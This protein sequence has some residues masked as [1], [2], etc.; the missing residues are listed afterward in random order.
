MGTMRQRP[1]RRKAADRGFT[2]V[3]LLIV[4][5]VVGI[6]AG[7]VVFGVFRFRDDANT[8]TDLANLKLLNNASA[9]YQASAPAGQS[10][11]DLP[12]DTARMNRLFDAKLLTNPPDGIK[13]ITPKVAG[14]SFTWNAASGLW[15]YLNGNT[16]DY[17]FA[18]DQLSNYPQTGSWT[19]TSQGFVST[20]GLLFVPNPRIEYTITSVATL[21]PGTGSGY[22]V[23]FNTSLGTGNLDTGYALQFDRGYSA[24]GDI[25]IR[26]RSAGNESGAIAR[27]NSANTAGLIPDKAAN[28]AWWA[29]QHTLTLNVTAPSATTRAL[30][31][32]IDGQTVFS[33]FTFA[34][35]A[36]PASSYTGFRSWSGSTTY[37]SLTTSGAVA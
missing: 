12:S 3:E 6:L 7:I 32:Q 8:A 10:L 27:Y 28:P 23:L 17:N 29:A 31:L 13:V 14:A 16:Q 25:V 22:G 37:H 5:V 15:L 18:S 24:S 21:G 20:A 11:S 9:A 30:A 34:N 19:Q 26:P 33:N 36:A 35:P 2:L 4:I 1:S